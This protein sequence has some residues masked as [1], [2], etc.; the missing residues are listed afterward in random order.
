MIKNNEIK[1]HQGNLIIE[2]KYD[3]YKIIL[4]ILTKMMMKSVY[5]KHKIV[6]KI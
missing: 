5:I 6:V 1:D 4:K 3:F 2:A